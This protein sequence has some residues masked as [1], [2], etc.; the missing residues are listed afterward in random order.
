MFPL[1]IGTLWKVQK[2]RPFVLS[3]NADLMFCVAPMQSQWEFQILIQ[4]VFSDFN[5]SSLY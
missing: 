2:I 4:A 5:P 1:S 3:V